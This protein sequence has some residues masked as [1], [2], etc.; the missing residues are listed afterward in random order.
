M[1][2]AFALANSSLTI[3]RIGARAVSVIVIVVVQVAIVAVNIERVITVIAVR[4]AL[5]L[6][7]FACRKLS[8]LTPYRIVLVFALKAF[9]IGDLSR[10]SAYC[11]FRTLLQAL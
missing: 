2:C 4:R 1:F 8:T 9:P 6:H 3:N 7:T 5:Q 10:K 11:I